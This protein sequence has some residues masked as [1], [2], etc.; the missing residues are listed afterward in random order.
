MRKAWLAVACG[1]LAIATLD[2]A[3]AG[4]RVYA[5]RGLV[6][7][8]SYGMDSMVDKCRA[9]GITAAAHS[10]SEYRDLAPEAAKLAKSGRGPIIIIG[11]SLGAD[12]A[13]SM[14]REMKKLGAPVALLVLFGPTVD[15]TIPS[16]VR[17]VLNYYQTTNLL[18]RGKA[19]G[20]SGFK[21][22]IRNINLDKDE[23]VTHFN[24]E[25]VERLQKQA[26]ARIVAL[27]GTARPLPPADAAA[28]SAAKRGAAAS[29]KWSTKEAGAQRSAH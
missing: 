4:G 26:M 8:F 5:L 11:H 21:G 6:N 3:L 25:K 29:P 17:S 18:W 9:R 27:T 12:A 2:S 16:N 15:A 13:V 14:A 7:V 28:S 24:I 10:H 1:I 19:M 20:G 23:D 22:S